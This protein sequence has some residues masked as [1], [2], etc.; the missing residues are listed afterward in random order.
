MS[1]RDAE[2]VA[3]HLDAIRRALDASIRALAQDLPQPLTPPQARAMEVLADSAQENPDGGGLSLSE[4][5][6]RLGLAHSTVSGI[7]DRL[8][9]DGLVRRITRAD[10]RRYRRIEI[11]AA[12]RD[13]LRDELPALRLRPLVTALEH[14]DEND[15][16]ALMRSLALLQSLL[17][18]QTTPSG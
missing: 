7:V 13:W 3:A 10:D 8:E 15:R 17:E 1:T 12:V 16:A 2:R 5:S 4:L 11:S 14:A 6:T 18:A 9:R